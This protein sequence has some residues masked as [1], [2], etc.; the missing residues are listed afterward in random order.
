MPVD[1]PESWIATFPF[2]KNRFACAASTVGSSR[3]SSAVSDEPSVYWPGTKTS[4]PTSSPSRRMT[5]WRTA[6]CPLKLFSVPLSN[7]S[8]HVVQ[9]ADDLVAEAVAR[10]DHRLRL[11]F[12]AVV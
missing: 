6:G 5:T 2:W 4:V 1:E 7:A 8:S 11:Q 3:R 9:R 12:L 10:L